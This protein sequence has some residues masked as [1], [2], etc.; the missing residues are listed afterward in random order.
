MPKKLWALAAIGFT[1]ILTLFSLINIDSLPKLGSDYDDKYF[2]V[3]A[4]G[5]LTLL[6]YLAMHELKIVKPLIVL[7]L[8]SIFYGIVLEVLQDILT[9]ARVFDI[10]DILANCIGVTIVALIIGIR[11]KTRV[12]NI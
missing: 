1:L 6:W 11:N 9:S 10:I 12:K 8:L 4:Y 2:H 5:L 7:A 3:L